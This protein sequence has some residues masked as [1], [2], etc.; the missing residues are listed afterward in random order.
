MAEGEDQ[1][2]LSVFDTVAQPDISGQLFIS[3]YFSC[4]SDCIK[5]QRYAQMLE[6]PKIVPNS[7]LTSNSAERGMGV[8]T[9]AKT[10]NCRKCGSD[11]LVRNGHDYKGSQKFEC[12]ACGFQ[13]TLELV[14]EYPLERKLEILRA[15]QERQ[16]MRGIERTFGVIRKTLANWLLEFSNLLPPLEDTLLEP[17][18][19]D[20][21]E[22]DNKTRGKGYGR[23]A[24]ENG[25]LNGC[26]F[27]I[28]CI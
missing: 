26:H 13:G 14:Q 10:C 7:E 2:L 18:P 25:S 23:C 19:D 21:L 1:V 8:I 6:S 17:Q 3:L 4:Q 9:I 22:L 16:S 12:Y 5:N 20:V 11:N 28:M 27:E 15:Y 24:K